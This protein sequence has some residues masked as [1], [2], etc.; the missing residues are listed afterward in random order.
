MKKV[1]QMILNHFD[2]VVAY[3]VA[4]NLDISAINPHA[5]A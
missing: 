3:L 4:G 2:G 5:K 1:A